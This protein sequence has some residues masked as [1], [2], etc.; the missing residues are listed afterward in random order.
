MAKYNILVV[1]D[2]SLIRSGI[3]TGINSLANNYHFIEVGDGKEAIETCMSQEIHLML[4]DIALPIL[5]GFAVIEALK[6]RRCN[7]KTIVFSFYTEPTLIF[8]LLNSGVHGYLPKSAAPA[9]LLEAIVNV[10]RGDNYFPKEFLNKLP[11]YVQD[12]SMLI[13]K[14]SKK[15]LEII[16]LLSQGLTSKEIAEETGYTK[17]SIE[18]KKLRIEKKFN[19]KS[20]SAVISLAYRMGILKI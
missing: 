14:F 19:A 18:T 7:V 9:Q 5:D 15:E 16:K 17:R 1:D 6:V 11:V 4:L 12:S 13:K 3:I 10:L 2:H 20:S 8:N